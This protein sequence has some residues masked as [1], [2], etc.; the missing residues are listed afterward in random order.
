MYSS[1]SVYKTLFQNIIYTSVH[2]SII[3]ATSVQFFFFFSDNNGVVTRGCLK[4]DDAATCKAEENCLTFEDGKNNQV[5]CKSCEG[6]DANCSQTDMTANDYK[7]NK[8]CDAGIT[9]CI[10]KVDNK[11]VVRGC[12]SDTEKCNDNN[13]CKIC[14]GDKCNQGIFPVNR[15][16]CYQCNGDKCNDVSAVTSKPCLNFDDKDE[17]YTKGENDTTMIRGCKSDTTANQCSTTATG[18]VYCATSKCNSLKYK[19]DQT[20]KCYQCTGENVDS[21]CFKEQTSKDFKA[22]T[23][24]ILYSDAEYCYSAVS[25][26][27]IKRGCLHDNKDLAAEACTGNDSDSCTKCN[28]ADGCN[29]GKKNAEEF[30][31]IVCRSDI[32]YKCYD[33]ATKFTGEKCR[34]GTSSSKDGCFHGLWS[35]YR[36]QLEF[37]L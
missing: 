35:K 19:H 14:E 18:C 16:Q 23:E 36:I 25:A 11:L 22:C 26:E 28:T 13:T 27:T 9:K 20:L 24:Q 29:S 10:A 8:V 33:E 34:T 21:D 12:A 1:G 15:V 3:L 37:I 32:D 7:Y 6:T 17:C 30:T 31:C 2:F 5:I 4:K